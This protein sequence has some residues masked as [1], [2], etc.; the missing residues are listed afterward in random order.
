[1]DRNLP[2]PR[3]T[4]LAGALA[5]LAALL[6]SAGCGGGSNAKLSG[7]VTY[8]GEP[9]S[10]TLTLQ[11]TGAAAPVTYPVPIA[12]DGR[13]STVGVPEGAYQV[14]VTPAS[15][16]VSMAP[17]MPQPPKDVS[18]PASP[19]PGAAGTPAKHIDIPAKYLR[20]ETSGL[21]WEVKSGAQTRDFE[22]TD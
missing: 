10:G 13:F 21:T 4:L 3:R 17:Q 15:A 11:S 16:N 6:A 2:R 20:P 14:G 7:K 1:M 22:L 9:V 8:K 12:A 19:Q 18:V 5:C